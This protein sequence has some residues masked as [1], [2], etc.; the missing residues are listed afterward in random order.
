MNR[1]YI[2][3]LKNKLK[4]GEALSPAQAMIICESTKQVFKK[5]GKMCL[6]LPIHRVEDAIGL[7]QN[8]SLAGINEVYVTC[9]YSNQ[10]NEWMAMDAHGMKLRG[11]EMVENS[12]YHSDIESWGSSKK[13]ELIPALKFSFEEKGKANK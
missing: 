10:L 11:I 5:F 9:E 6:S 13:P 3:Q 2:E 4:A 1:D 8:L 7:V 12:D